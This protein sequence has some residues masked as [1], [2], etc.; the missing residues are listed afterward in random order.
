MTHQQ[1]AA[2]PQPPTPSVEPSNAVH[3]S[4]WPWCPCAQC[5]PLAELRNET[6]PSATRE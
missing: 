3:Q 5:E 4:D 6:P 2:A 1:E